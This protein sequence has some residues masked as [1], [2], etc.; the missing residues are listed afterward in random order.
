MKKA[1]EVIIS[2]CVI[3]VTII[4]ANHYI[5]K[6]Q[7]EKQ[8]FELRKEKLKLEIQILNIDETKLKNGLEIQ[9]HEESS[10]CCPFCK[11]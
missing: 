1:T 11:S 7:R 3:I 8:F 2:V 5:Q 10:K 4:I 9:R 6:N